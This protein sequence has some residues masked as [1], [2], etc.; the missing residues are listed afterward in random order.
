MSNKEGKITFIGGRN[1]GRKVVGFLNKRNENLTDLFVEGTRVRGSGFVPF[2]DLI[3]ENQR[4][5]SVEKIRDYTEQIRNAQP[6]II[7]V[8]GCSEII[9]KDILNI[10]RHGVIGFHYAPLPDRRGCNPVMWTLIHGLT[11]SGVTAFYYDRGIDTGDIIDIGRFPVTSD[12]DSKSLLEKCESSILGLLEKHLDK[13]KNETASRISQNGPGIYTPRRTAEDGKIDWATTTAIDVFNKV[14]ALRPP[15]LGAYAEF[16]SIKDKKRDRIYILKV[17]PVDK[18]DE[19]KVIDWKKY[20]P[21]QVHDMV[22][23]GKAFSLTG[24]GKLN[25]LE[26]RLSELKE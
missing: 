14:R 26:T 21:E 6:D 1:A 17:E 10:P 9:S 25:I 20:T 18:L 19:S 16:G 7:L 3:K 15:Y 22:K 5:Y 23:N 11:E 8:A 2:D 4:L 12:D 24:N 13:L